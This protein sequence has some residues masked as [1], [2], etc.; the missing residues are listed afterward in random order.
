MAAIG[1]ISPTVE[2]ILLKIKSNFFGTTMMARRIVGIDAGYINFAVCG[3]RTDDV[4]HP[5]YWVNRPLFFG[6]FSEER[7][8]AALVDWINLPE[9][10]ELLDAADEIVLE[11]QMVMK[12]QA[13]NHCVFFRYPNKTTIV[14][15]KTIQT[16]FKLPEGKKAKKKGAVDLVGT[17]CIFPVKR[18]KK[19]DLADSFLLALWAG[20]R[21]KPSLAQNFLPAEQ[22]KGLKRSKLTLD[23]VYFFCALFALA[24]KWR[25]RSKNGS[26]SATQPSWTFA[27]PFFSWCILTCSLESMEARD[28]RLE[29]ISHLLAPVDNFVTGTTCADGLPSRAPIA[30]KIA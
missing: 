7:L 20:A 24:E 5:Y 27:R 15:P 16:F 19:D 26:S 11:R 4:E 17:R 2:A 12:Y 1:S 8:R 13:V 21:S 28:K 25:G 3:I 6:K 18:G 30:S 23:L 22:E 14:H 29:L 9:V 10:R